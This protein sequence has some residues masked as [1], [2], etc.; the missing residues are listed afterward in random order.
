MCTQLKLLL[1]KEGTHF[2]QMLSQPGTIKTALR[3]FFRD[4]WHDVCK[5]AFYVRDT[6]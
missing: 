1:V 4:E 6:K 3:F 5:R 2:Y